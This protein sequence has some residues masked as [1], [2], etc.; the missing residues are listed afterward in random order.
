M[1]EGG[2]LLNDSTLNLL[3]VEQYMSSNNF[4]NNRDARS[5]IRK[6]KLVVYEIKFYSVELVAVTPMKQ[7]LLIIFFQFN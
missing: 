6:V 1:I 4:L 5:Q 7:L 2:Y 3:Q